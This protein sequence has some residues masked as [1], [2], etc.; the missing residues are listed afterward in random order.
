METVKL[1]DKI[2]EMKDPNNKFVVIA[3]I[4]NMPTDR[5]SGGIGL[6]VTADFYDS[7]LKSR[8]ICIKTDNDEG[9]AYIFGSRYPVNTYIYV[10]YHNNDF[11]NTSVIDYTDSQKPV[12]SEWMTDLDNFDYDT[13][14]YNEIAKSKDSRILFMGETVGGDVG[15]SVYV[16]LDENNDVNSIIID[17][18][19]CIFKDS[20]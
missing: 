1:I 13:I 12:N 6:E 18:C 17:V 15:A 7:Y 16:H 10:G 19:D 9:N 11:A 8:P 3:E 5:F 4:G 20:E 2:E 14:E